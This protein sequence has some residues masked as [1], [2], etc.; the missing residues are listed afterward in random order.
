MRTIF[1][2]SGFDIVQRST[3]HHCFIKWIPFSRGPRTTEQDE[4]H[5]VQNYEAG[6]VR[7]DGW[8]VVPDYLVRPSVRRNRPGPGTAPG[9]G[10]TSLLP[11]RHSVR[12]RGSCAALRHQ[13]HPCRDAYLSWD[14]VPLLLESLLRGPVFALSSVFGGPVTGFLPPQLRLY[15]FQA[16]L[17]SD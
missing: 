11:T 4:L 16:W 12:G 15:R 3:G 1:L 7:N 17:S 5:W 8:H 13:D 2:P 10:I 6:G 14:G 9:W